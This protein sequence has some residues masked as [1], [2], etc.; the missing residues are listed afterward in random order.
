[1]THMDSGPPVYRLKRHNKD[2]PHTCVGQV[3]FFLLPFFFPNDGP[4]AAAAGRVRRPPP[5]SPPR[6][7]A[8]VLGP[9]PT[10]PPRSAA[11]HHP[12][13]KSW[14][15]LRRQNSSLATIPLGPSYGNH[16]FSGADDPHPTPKP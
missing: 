8:A 13:P 4:A 15:R 3:P 10:A 5:P 14:P 9:L 2:A 1:M 7:A 6:S 12:N 11:P 16:F